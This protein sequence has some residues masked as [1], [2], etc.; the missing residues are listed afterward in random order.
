MPS[1]KPIRPH[2]D[3]AVITPGNRRGPIAITGVC[4]GDPLEA[5][6][7]LEDPTLAVRIPRVA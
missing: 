5:D 2:E 7:A 4:G 3:T 6:A 1:F